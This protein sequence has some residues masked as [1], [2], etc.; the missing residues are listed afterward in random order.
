MSKKNAP[1]TNGN[2][3]TNT[4]RHS[5][6]L[7]MIAA[8]L[9]TESLNTF[10]AIRIGDTCLHSTVSSLR[11]RGYTIH[12]EWEEVRNRFGGTTRVKR[13]RILREPG[14]RQ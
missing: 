11:R 10:E 7:A 13:Y 1:A 5:T 12:S 6:K 3:S 9:R 8:I 2:E 14:A 4:N